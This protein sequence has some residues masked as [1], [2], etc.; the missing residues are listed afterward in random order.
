MR[1]LLSNNSKKRLF[2]FLKEKYKVNNLWKLSKKMEM[3]FST[4]SN[5]KKRKGY[6]PD[7]IIPKEYLNKLNIIDKKPD[8]WWQVK[9]GKIGGKK[10]AEIQKKRLGKKD[11]I[12]VMRQRGRKVIN[13]IWKRYGKE[14]VTSMAIRG[15]LKKRENESQRLERENESYFKNKKIAL[16]CK[17]V[18]YT[19]NDIK[20]GIIFP[21]KMT[22]E[23]AEEIGVHLGDG[24]LSKNRNYFSVKTN[25][26][27]EKYML[28]LFK[29]YKKIY[30]L[31]LKLMKLPSV[32]GFE[33]YS[34][35]LC[36]FKNKILGLP[37]GEKIHRIEVPKA[38][39][40]TKNKDI[41][42]ALIRG[43]FD[44]DGCICIN[45]KNGKDYPIISLCVLS[46][47][48]ILQVSKMLERLGY[49][50]FHNKQSINLNGIVMF[51][52][53]VEEIGSSN[54]KNFNKLRW[55]SSITDS[56]RPCGE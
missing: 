52:K 24:C 26:R 7:K 11:Y 23:L 45:K 16:N 50:T 31:D 30:N 51:K 42:R 29:L 15:K 9:G 21:N 13:T 39:L 28:Y 6:L 25:K 20:K 33:V 27:E 55:A 46:E 32:V 53:W 54:P 5:W 14:E 4:L 49:I 38:I 22:S 44:T 37:Y 10:C 47:K 34:K 35:A 48:L 40:N 43:L 17:K 36:E 1:I 3:P 41:Y 19:P 2:D 56:T 18:T 8:N 12:E